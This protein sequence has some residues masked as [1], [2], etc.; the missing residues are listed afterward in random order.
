MWTI[1]VADRLRFPRFPSELG[2]RGNAHLRPHTHRH[3]SQQSDA[4]W[5]F[6]KQRRCTSRCTDNDWSRHRNQRGYTLRSGSG[7]LTNGVHLND[8]GR[9]PIPRPGDFVMMLDGERRPRFIWRTSERRVR[10]PCSKSGEPLPL[11]GPCGPRLHRCS[12]GHLPWAPWVRITLGR[13]S[14]VGSLARSSSLPAR[15]DHWTDNAPI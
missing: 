15:R 3:Y 7:C 12:V 11:Q 10:S 4:Y 13:L 1:G 8:D 2:R 9:E 5:W 14:R 6:E